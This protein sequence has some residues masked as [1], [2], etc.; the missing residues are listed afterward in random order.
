MEKEFILRYSNLHQPDIT[1]TIKKCN[2]DFCTMNNH[3]CMYTFNNK[4]VYSLKIVRHI[5]LI[6]SSTMNECYQACNVVK[7]PTHSME[8]IK[9]CNSRRDDC[10]VSSE[11]R[12]CDPHWTFAGSQ[13]MI[14][15]FYSHFFIIRLH[16]LLMSLLLVL[17][18]CCHFL[19]M[20]MKLQH[21][22]NIV[23]ASCT[24]VYTPCGI[25]LDSITIFSIRG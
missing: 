17:H 6:P 12:L 2:V 5:Y 22:S 10:V 1:I 8:V 15:Q 18:K 24:Y 9:A 21:K 7:N 3:I 16:A 20:R 23:F 14:C 11:S 19:M 13:C 4:M 25:S